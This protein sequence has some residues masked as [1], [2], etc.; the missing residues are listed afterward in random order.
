MLF[1]EI[2]SFYVITK[3]YTN[4]DIN[5]NA[6]CYICSDTDIPMTDFTEEGENENE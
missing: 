6:V 5:H 3:Q 4:P 1:N 2:L